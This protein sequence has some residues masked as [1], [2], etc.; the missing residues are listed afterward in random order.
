MSGKRYSV[1]NHLRIELLLPV[2]EEILCEGGTIVGAWRRY[3]SPIFHPFLFLLLVPNIL[4]FHFNL[5]TLQ[6]P[7]L[8]FHEE[9]DLLVTNKLC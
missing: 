3:L 7:G 5:R 6:V 4:V 9:R 2:K 8:K 1:L